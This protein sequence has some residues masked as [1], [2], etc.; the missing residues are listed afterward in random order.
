MSHGSGAKDRRRR[1]ARYRDA[2]YLH[3][4]HSRPSWTVEDQFYALRQTRSRHRHAHRF[5][6][7]S[8]LLD[9][10]LDVEQGLGVFHW[11]MTVIEHRRV[12]GLL[13]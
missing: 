4:R 12:A 10:T 2:G 6:S 13:G 5:H 7:Q 3:S 1:G 8:S 11:V 9:R